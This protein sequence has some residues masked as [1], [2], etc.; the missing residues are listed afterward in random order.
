MHRCARPA[1][2][3]GGLQIYSLRQELVDS[4]KMTNRQFHDALL[5]ESRIPVEMI[6]ASLTR[7]PLTLQLQIF[8]TL[9]RYTASIANRAAAVWKIG[10]HPLFG[11]AFRFGPCAGPFFVGMPTEPLLRD[12]CPIPDGPA[13]LPHS[14]LRFPVSMMYAPTRAAEAHRRSLRLINLPS[15]TCQ[16]RL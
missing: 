1:Y 8:V 3:L 13:G 14:G 12:C 2:L 6:R 11:R 5:K 10:S 9:F 7:Q 16:G 15:D 4:G